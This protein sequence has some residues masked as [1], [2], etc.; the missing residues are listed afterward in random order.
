[1]YLITLDSKKVLDAFM[2][3]YGKNLL[4]KKNVLLLQDTNNE[5][6]GKFGPKKYPSLF[7][8]SAAQKLLVY[9]DDELDLNKFS[10]FTETK[11]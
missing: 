11:N 8:Y 2:G 7:L 9:S 5:F 4:N 3:S 1:M 6:I 10:S